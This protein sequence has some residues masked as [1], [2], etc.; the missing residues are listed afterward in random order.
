MRR[1]RNPWILFLILLFGAISGSAVGQ[2]LSR[3]VPLLGASV[4]GGLEPPITLNLVVL[5]ITFGVRFVANVGTALGV[6]L[7]IM[8][9]SG[10]R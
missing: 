1:D 8:L 2:I 6:M 4:G 9:Y 10:R 3:Y 7:A 5:S